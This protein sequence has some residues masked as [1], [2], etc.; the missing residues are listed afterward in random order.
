MKYILFFVLIISTASCLKSRYN[1]GHFN[2]QVKN[3]TEVNSE[4]DDYNSD[5]QEFGL[6]YL[7]SFSSNRNSNGKDYDIVGAD[8]SVVWNKTNGN[9]SILYDQ[10]NDEFD[11]LMPM[12]DSINTSS[13][14]LGPFSIGYRQDISYTEVLWTDLFMYAN[15]IEGNY[16]IRYIYHEEFNNSDTTI[17]QLM[18][19]KDLVFINTDAN[20]LYPSFYGPDF[21]YFDLY[22][23]EQKKI[24]RFVYCSDKEGIYN[25]FEIV[26]S[27]D[28]S[29]TAFLNSKEQSKSEKIKISSESD[30]K[31]P[32]VNGKSLVFASNRSG[33]YGGYDLYYSVIKNGEWS[34]PKNFGNKINSEFDEYR[35]ITLYHERFDNNLLIFSSNRPGGKGGYDLY[36]SGINNIIN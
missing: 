16:D 6:Y 11:F 24:E 20:E 29:L 13:N 1:T 22:G 27:I 3:F 21:F 33:G 5:I 7:L 2:E 28:S 15:D 4:F 17:S 18:G 31:C 12:L 23:L 32:F 19:P 30:D 35:P 14:E 9:L 36:Y 8:L 26:V 10:P 25:I 34:E